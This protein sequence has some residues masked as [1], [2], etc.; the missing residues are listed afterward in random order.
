MQ[1]DHQQVIAAIKE[2]EVIEL[3]QNLI[4]IPSVVIPDLPGH[5]EERVAHY[6]ADV[7]SKLGAE[8][9]VEDVEP[10][11][12]NVIGIVRGKKPGKCLLLEAHTDVVTPG[13]RSGWKYDPFGAEIVGRRI[14]GRG[15]CDTKNGITSAIMAI[16]GILDAG[17]DFPG[18]IKLA[19]P[20]DEEGMM[21]GIKHFIKQGWADDVDAALICEPED[22]RICIAQKGAMRVLVYIKGKQAHGCMPYSGVNPNIRMARF[23]SAVAAYEERERRR[24]GRHQYLGVPSFTPTVVQA[25]AEGVGQVN[26]IPEC[27]S[28]AYDIRT[29]TGQNHE[30]VFAD[31][32]AIAKQLE[33]TDQDKIEI[34]LEWIE[35][36]PVTETEKD[37]PLVQAVVAAYQDVTGK[38]AVYD[39]VP[40]ATDGTFLM[41]QKNIPVVVTGSGVREVPHQYDEW[42][43]IDQL[44]ETTRIYA[45]AIL[46][47]L[48]GEI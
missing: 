28:I 40:G 6:V 35:D 37:E 3:L 21:I 27:C 8:V 30:Q 43:D 32:K 31:L 48:K 33:D 9:H 10:G 42:V 29:I 14:Y 1:P 39:G 38:E 4:R 24:L 17:I 26:V 2:N 34:K 12:P 23:I 19:M 16:K 15:A 13:D 44:M 5:N 7:L 25:P 20:V 47:Y 11:R 41:S 45:L 36:R 22:N 46:R 18:T